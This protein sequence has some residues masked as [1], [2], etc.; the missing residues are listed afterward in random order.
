MKFS[1]KHFLKDAL[2]VFGFALILLLLMCGESLVDFVIDSID[3]D[4]IMSILSIVAVIFF[5]LLI[6]KEEK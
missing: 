2:E 4:I 1:I 6:M 5:V 3:A